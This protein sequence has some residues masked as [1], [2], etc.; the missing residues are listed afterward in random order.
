MPTF[1]DSMLTKIQ[2]PLSPNDAFQFTCRQCG[3]C[4]RKRESPIMLTGFDVFRIAKSLSIDPYAALTRF[5]RGYLEGSSHIPV[6]VLRERLDGSCTLLRNG[7]C[8]VHK[9]KPLACAMYPL[10]RYIDFSTQKSG[11]FLQHATCSGAIDGRTYTLA[12]WLDEWGISDDI[13]QAS[14]AWEKLAGFVGAVMC[15][16]P[17]ESISRDMV[18]ELYQYLYGEYDVQKDFIPQVRLNGEMLSQRLKDGWGVI[19]DFNWQEGKS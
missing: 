13:D 5:T 4:C 16:I 14:I 8:S 19:L 6:V 15:R 10:G 11:Y 2:H 7:K 9:H 12:S 18:W 1:N 3:E 17:P